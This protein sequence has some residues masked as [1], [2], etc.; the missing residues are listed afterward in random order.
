MLEE[1]SVRKQREMRCQ[2]EQHKPTIR[3]IVFE[4]ES[5]R[6]ARRDAVLDREAYLICLIRRSMWHNLFSGIETGSALRVLMFLD[7]SYSIDL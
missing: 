1:N 2:S 3:A 5:G 7:I 6:V 4:G